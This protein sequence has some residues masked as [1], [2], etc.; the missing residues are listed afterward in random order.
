MKKTNEF[1]IVIIGC[2]KVGG[3][4]A[5]MASSIGHSVVVIDKN[6]ESFENLSPEFTGFTIIGDATEKD[7]LENAK[8]SKAD[9]VFV[10]T[11]DDNTN[12]LISLQCKYYFGAK[13]IISRIYDPEN[14]VLFSEYNIDVVSPTMLLI[15][16]LKNILVGESL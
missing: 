7:V 14:S 8:V 12:F 5:S 1:F 16:D 15:G 3:N 11:E 4:I 10:L 9:Y 2:G 6:Q 13:N